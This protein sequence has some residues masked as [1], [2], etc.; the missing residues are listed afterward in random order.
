MNFKITLE[1]DG[2]DFHGWQRQKTERS[3]QEEIEKVLETVTTK[4]ITLHG[5]GRTDAGVHALG[6]TAGFKCETD[7]TPQTLMKA[8][9]S[10]LP[11]D[12]VVLS[13]EEVNDDFHARFSVRSKVYQYRILNQPLPS[14]FHRRYAWHIPKNL[15]T[16][17]MEKAM[18]YIRGEHDFSAFE[19]AGSPRSHSVRHM[20]RAEI[21]RHKNGF[22]TLEFEANGFL[23]FMVRNIVGT[24]VDVGLGKLP[25]EGFNDILESKDRNLA[26]I[27]APPQGL[28]LVKVNYD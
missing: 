9:N 14:V 8:L 25:P 7:L 21:T 22:I 3:V 19:G 16:D 27:T 1:Y 28:F 15:D 12:I 17:A 18:E 26:G 13:C 5:S 4:K 24:L 10:L 2:T 20:M 6:Q 23:K 11:N